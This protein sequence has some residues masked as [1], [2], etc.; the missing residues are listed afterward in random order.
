MRFLGNYFM[1]K[2]TNTHDFSHFKNSQ[3]VLENLSVDDFKTLSARTLADSKSVSLVE[4]QKSLESFFP[5]QTYERLDGLSAEN[6]VQQTRTKLNKSF[7]AL[8]NIVKERKTGDTLSR[9]VWEIA[10]RDIS[11]QIS[12][13]ELSGKIYSEELGTAYL[14]HLQEAEKKA[15]AAWDLQNKK[16]TDVLQKTVQVRPFLGSLAFLPRLWQRDVVRTSVPVLS[17]AALG[18]I[19]GTQLGALFGPLRSAIG[20]GVGSFSGAVSG[21]FFPEF[22]QKIEMDGESRALRKNIRRQEI[23]DRYHENF[24]PEFRLQLEKVFA[25]QKKVAEEIRKNGT[26]R[27]EEFQKSIQARLESATTQQRAELLQQL[28]QLKKNPDQRTLSAAIQAFAPTRHADKQFRV[29]FLE[30]VKRMDSLLPLLS[31]Q[32]K[33]DHRAA[34]DETFFQS[35]SQQQNTFTQTF[36]LTTRLKNV[37]TNMHQFQNFTLDEKM[38][39]AQFEEATNNKDVPNSEDLFRKIRLDLSAFRK[40][41]DFLRKFSSSLSDSA[42]YCPSLRLLIALEYLLIEQPKLL[43]DGTISPETKQAIFYWV[44]DKNKNTISQEVVHNADREKFLKDYAQIFETSK[45]QMENLFQ[46]RDKALE[47]KGKEILTLSETD[48]KT[49]FGD[50]RTLEDQLKRLFYL[51][52]KIKNTLGNKKSSILSVIEKLQKQNKDSYEFLKQLE[53]LRSKKISWD[54][55][56]EKNLK[57][58]TEDIKELR[59]KIKQKEKELHD[60]KQK[61]EEEKNKLLNDLSVIEYSLKY[62]HNSRQ[63]VSHFTQE[64]QSLVAQQRSLQQKIGIQDKILNESLPKPDFEKLEKKESEKKKL[65]EDQDFPEQK[66]VT[67]FRDIYQNSRDFFLEQEIKNPTEDFSS[68]KN[69]AQQTLYQRIQSKLFEDFTEDMEKKIS[70]ELRTVDFF[71]LL[72]K[73]EI[74]G[75]KFEVE[76]VDSAEVRD[77]YH[78]PLDFDQRKKETFYLVEQT[79]QGFLFENKFRTTQ[80]FLTQPL[81]DGQKFGANAVLSQFHTAT[82]KT[83]RTRAGLV[84]HLRL[85]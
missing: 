81:F 18:G 4:I 28:L 78:L 33:L 50:N 70:Q 23:Q 58:I 44:A 60:K 13:I 68:H 19:L 14:E 84:T 12:Q 41:K 69:Y 15:L 71:S 8:Q 32:K 75:G 2:I 54:E 9:E 5:A 21:L 79:S 72:K 56:Q 1:P 24:H 85:F 82:G 61:A 35:V 37:L 46:L 16:N 26:I 76:Y 77:E 6:L 63:Q 7:S 74:L 57:Q 62:L 25:E 39:F 17:G 36:Q 67:A 73:S 40:E 48:I 43:I 11:Q 29:S 34:T 42:G 22:L 55:K 45:K 47:N 27:A 38:P 51:Y 30:A 65:E 66:T 10:G 64:M 52:E 53:S 83:S 31:L 3:N 59:E 49:L 80:L 20:G